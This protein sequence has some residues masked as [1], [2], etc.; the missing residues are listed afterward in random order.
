[1]V[2]LER[3]TIIT[4]ACAAKIIPLKFKAALSR[5]SP[6]TLQEYAVTRQEAAHSPHAFLVRYAHT[7]LA[8]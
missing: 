2:A 6:I 8:T 1:M 4:F 5:Q 3:S 7:D